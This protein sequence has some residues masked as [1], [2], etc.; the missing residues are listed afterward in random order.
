MKL[1]VKLMKFPNW[2]IIFIIL[3]LIGFLIREDN[4][5]ILFIKLIIYST[6]VIWSLLCSVLNYIAF[7][8]YKSIVYIPKDMEMRI[9][10]YLIFFIILSLLSL[11]L[12]IYVWWK[13]LWWFTLASTVGAEGFTL[14]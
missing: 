12:V 8:Y 13:A 9:I 6:A 11:L 1:I 10:L 5:L 4:I 7:Y 3:V 14:V 2:S